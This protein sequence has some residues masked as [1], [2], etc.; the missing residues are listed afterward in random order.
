MNCKKCNSDAVV[1]GKWYTE[2]GETY[3]LCNVCSEVMDKLPTNMHHLFFHPEGSSFEEI[4]RHL[5]VPLW[6][7]FRGREQRCKSIEID[8]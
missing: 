2:G 3:Y 1:E 4:K 7:M 8:K 6:G 5:S